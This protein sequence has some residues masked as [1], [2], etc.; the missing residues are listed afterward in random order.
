[1]VTIDT[2]GLSSSSYISI[3]SLKGFDA[4]VLCNSSTVLGLAEILVGNP[5]GGLV[6]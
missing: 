6:N 5:A 4:L 3:I 2:Y 1:V